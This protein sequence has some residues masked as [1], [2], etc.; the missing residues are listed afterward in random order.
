MNA[1]KHPAKFSA[2]IVEHLRVLAVE[3]VT[4]GG[5]ILDP[6]AGVGRIHELRRDGFDTHGIELEPEWAQQGPLK[7][8]VG[9]S[10]RAHVIFKHTRFDALITSPCY[11]NRMADHQQAAEKC[12]LCKGTGYAT[13]LSA[14]A[15][16][17][18]EGIGRNTYTRNTYTH[19]LGRKL[20]EG[21]AG[22]MQWGDEYMQLHDDVYASCLRVLTDDAVVI[23]NVSDHIRRG[24]R[25]PVAGWHFE[26][27]TD[28][29]F[30]LV[31]VVPVATAR[32]RNG[33]NAAARV[34][35]EL[36]A[37]FRP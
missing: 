12:K 1:V 4:A 9:D 21:N 10:R 7:N 8:I 32:N 11:G 15:C 14:D 18:C 17:R 16:T 30:S 5:L 37:V 29:G 19:Q 25:Q 24:V 13:H 31:D 3:H 23:L 27:W 22:A 35:A 28:A 2:P 33:A 6:F 36:I 26:W 34:D 20:T